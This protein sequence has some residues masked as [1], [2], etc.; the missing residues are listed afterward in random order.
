MEIDFFKMYPRS[1]S[2]SI[3]KPKQEV[4]WPCEESGVCFQSTKAL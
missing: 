4:V 2:R 3:L 1:N